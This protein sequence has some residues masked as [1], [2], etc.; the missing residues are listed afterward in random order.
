[1]TRTRRPADPALAA[2]LRLLSGPPTQTA[3]GLALTRTG[4]PADRAPTVV[5]VHG[6]GSARSAWAPLLDGLVGRYHVVALDLPGHGASRPLAADEPADPRSL[7]ARVHEALQEAGIDRPHLVGNSLG[8]WVGLELAADDRVR[9]LTAL[10]P[11]GLRLHP[12]RPNRWLAL[13]RRLA[14]WTGPVADPLLASATVRRLTLA[15]GSADPAALDVGLARAAALAMRTGTGYERAL[16]GTAGRRFDRAG[17]V[18]VPVTVVFG[19][20]DRI[21]PAPRNQAREAA[22]AH[23]RWV[24]VRRCG[25]A[26]MWDAPQECLRLV[27]ETVAAAEPEGRGLAG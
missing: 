17:Q 4:L 16:D 20:D 5:L 26:P 24:L 23:A 6:L 10:A 25:H 7:A 21:L 15:S 1:M 3:A 18:T 8:G 14:A 19:D 2:G 13:N 9:G 27:D 11:A 22:P 12:G